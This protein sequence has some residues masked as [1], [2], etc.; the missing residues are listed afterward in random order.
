MAG[1]ANPNLK[2]FYQGASGDRGEGDVFGTTDWTGGANKAG[3]NAC[4]IGVN[5][6]D[7]DPKVSDWSQDERLLQNSQTISHTAAAITLD[8]DPDF[9]DNVSFVQADGNIAPDGEI[10]A[11]TAA[12][13]KTGKTIPTGSW[14]WGQVAQ[15]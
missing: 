11:G 2:T 1:V 13:N 8:Q 7:Y 6:G 4:G 5:T 12:A 9:N 15:A 3:S 10:K 14:A